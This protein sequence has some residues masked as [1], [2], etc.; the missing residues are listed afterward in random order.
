MNAH[1]P[2]IIVKHA[3][4]A[5]AQHAQRRA[6]DGEQ[7]MII[8]V[9]RAQIAGDFQ[10]FLGFARATALSK[11]RSAPRSPGASSATRPSAFSASAGR[12]IRQHKAEGREQCGRI[13]RLAQA[14]IKHAQGFDIL[15]ADAARRRRRAKAKIA[16]RFGDVGF[17]KFSGRLALPAQHAHAC[18]RAVQGRIRPSLDRALSKAS[19]SWRAPA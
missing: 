19:A 2:I 1:E 18:E 8:G 12:S 11:L 14:K 4:A 7:I 10:R 9:G 16:G 15:L 13:R 3:M 6:L 5:I 17:Q